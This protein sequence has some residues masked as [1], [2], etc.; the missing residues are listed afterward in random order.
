MDQPQNERRGKTI[1]RLP[2]FLSVHSPTAAL[3][4]LSSVA[5]SSEQATRNVTHQSS[6][7]AWFDGACWPNQGTGGHG[8]Y[9][10]IVRRDNLVIS[11]E[12]VYLGYDALINS[13][14]CEY[15]GITHVLRF[16]LKQGILHATIYGDCQTVI[17]Q[18]D[19]LAKTRGG[20]YLRHYYEARELR[21]QL[22][23]VQ[24]V[25]ISRKI[26]GEADALARAPIEA[27]LNRRIRR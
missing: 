13:E 6:I 2:L 3:G 12:S 15:A 27:I 11:A 8:S 7:T 16:L 18:L 9:G 19:G 4:S 10:A 21:S 22:P 25:W 20:K 1:S 17:Q 5:L 26:N 14:I 24:L 23:D